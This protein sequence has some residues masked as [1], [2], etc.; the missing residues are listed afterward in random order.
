VA[1]GAARCGVS[2]R[3]GLPVRL[4]NYVAQRRHPFSVVFLTLALVLQMVPVW[5]FGCPSTVSSDLGTQEGAGSMHACCVHG[6]HAC[7]AHRHGSAADLSSTHSDCSCQVGSVPAAPARVAVA[8]LVPVVAVVLPQVPPLALHG[9]IFSELTNFGSGS[10]PPPAASYL[11]DF[12]RAPP[13]NAL[14]SR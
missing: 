1:S 13:G 11:P 14:N 2:E 12:G 7:C 4:Y 8:G 3:L 6:M 9:G 5:A 10:S